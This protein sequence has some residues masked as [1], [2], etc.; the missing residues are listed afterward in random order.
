MKARVEFSLVF[1]VTYSVVIVG[2][3]FWAGT[4][5]GPLAPEPK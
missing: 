3:A 2:L 1:F 5:W 4:M